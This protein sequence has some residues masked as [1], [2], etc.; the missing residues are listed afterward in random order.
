MSLM[1]L[2]GIRHVFR[3]GGKEVHA[4]NG[5]SL[6][7]GAGETVAVIGESG[8]GKSTLGRIALGLITPTTGEVAFD[9]T[10]LGTLRKPALR[11]LRSRVQVVFQEPYESL[12]PRIKVGDIVAEP[13][14]IH[15][16]ELSREQRREKVVAMLERVGLTAEHADRYPRNLSG[17][18][19]QRIGIARAIITRP[20]L[21]VLDEP[22]S[23]LD[24]SVRARVLDLLRD[25]QREQGISYIFISHDLATVGLISDRVA[26]MYLGQIV[27]QGPTAEVLGNPKHPYTKAL[28]SATLST[29][30]G[31]RREHIPLQGEIPNPSTAPT[32]CVLSGRCPIEIDECSA[33][34]VAFRPVAE[35]HD[36]ACLRAERSDALLPTG[37]SA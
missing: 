34:P 10:V 26:V 29:V 25:L 22:T 1:E 24:V 15:D 5:V 20:E 9:G 35:G 8:S 11:A 16:R 33:G 7:V 31:E 4:V 17:G 18:Q 28:M 12:N 30:V 6:S 23:S 3:R 21:V 27:E 36:V 13:L 14:V 2:T 19:Q 37:E 32:A